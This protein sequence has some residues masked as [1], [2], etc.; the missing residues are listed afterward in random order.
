VVSE[1]VE[2][3]ADD[4]DEA[5]VVFVFACCWE[6]RGF[7]LLGGRP[8]SGSR[9]ALKGGR[10]DMAPWKGK[11]V[12]PSHGGGPPP[13]WIV[14]VWR[15]AGRCSKLNLQRNELIASETNSIRES[16]S[17]EGKL[18]CEETSRKSI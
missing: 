10:D 12:A 13:L 5:M 15:M 3:A 17:T 6:G 11:A 7:V 1:A 4:D 2:E 14:C 8:E 18:I 9:T 16:F